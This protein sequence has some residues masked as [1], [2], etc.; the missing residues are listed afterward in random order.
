VRTRAAEISQVSR[1]TQGV[2]LMRLAADESLQA[3][4]RVD[5]SLDDEE[6]E[7]PVASRD[8][9]DELVRTPPV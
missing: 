5:A 9:G 8:A 1:N 3:V 2:T 4:E 7:S 6:E